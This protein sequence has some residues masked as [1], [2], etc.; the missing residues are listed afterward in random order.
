MT[1]RHGIISGRS[2][3]GVTKRARLAMTDDPA[4][5]AETEGARR[6]LADSEAVLEDLIDGFR[7]MS[8][9]LSV[10]EDVTVEVSKAPMA[11]AS[12][13]AS[14]LDEVRRNESRILQAEGL[15]AT[16]D[17]DQIRFDIGR[18]LD[19]I[20][21]ARGADGISGGDDEG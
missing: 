20:R 18:R 5:K 15:M 9:R 3:L 13:R 8:D 12:V 1:K 11:L 7:R 19:R 6:L 16:A 2:F 21:D 4:A 14:I 10:G 17:L